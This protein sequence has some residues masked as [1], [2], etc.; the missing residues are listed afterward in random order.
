MGPPRPS[1][2][3][4]MADPARG[5]ANTSLRW[6]VASF[7]VVI[8]SSLAIIVMLQHRITRYEASYAAATQRANA[9]VVTSMDFRKG[10]DYITVEWSGI[11]AVYRRHTFDV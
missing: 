7:V 9:T 4:P 2:G 5:Y 1:D 10:Q 3:D 8:G 6:V 11:D